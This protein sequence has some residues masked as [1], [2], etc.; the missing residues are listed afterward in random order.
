MP[1][2][3]VVVMPFIPCVI[4]ENRDEENK[5]TSRNSRI[6][7]IKVICED[8]C[9]SLTKSNYFLHILNVFLLPYGSW[10]NKEKIKIFI[11]KEAVL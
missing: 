5:R 8:V 2:I 3:P 4:C 7:F 1:F 9:R 11:L 6:F 10:V